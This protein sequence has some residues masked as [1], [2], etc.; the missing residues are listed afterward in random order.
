MMKYTVSHLCRVVC[1]I[2][3]ALGGQGGFTTGLVSV[4]VSKHL[5]GRVVLPPKPLD[6]NMSQTPDRPDKAATLLLPS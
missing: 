3:E 4:G 5:D 2:L 6:L 1:Q